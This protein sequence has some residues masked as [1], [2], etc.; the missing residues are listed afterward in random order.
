MRFDVFILLL[1]FLSKMHPEIKTAVTSNAD[2]NIIFIDI[3]SLLLALISCGLKNVTVSLLNF[4]CY[5]RCR[6]ILVSGRA[7]TRIGNINP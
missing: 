5:S 1:P 6:F 3:F 7:G 4:P 2:S